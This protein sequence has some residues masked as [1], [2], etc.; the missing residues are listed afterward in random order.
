[1]FQAKPI[2]P[3]Y[4]VSTFLYHAYKYTIVIARKPYMSCFLQM[5]DV[6]TQAQTTRSALGSQRAMFGDVQG[7]VKQLGDKFPVVRGLIGMTLSFMFLR[8][9]LTISFESVNFVEYVCR[10][11]QKEETKGY[12]HPIC[13]HRGLYVV[14]YYILAIKVKKMLC[15][16]RKNEKQYCSRKKFCPICYRIRNL[17]TFSLFLFC[18]LCCKHLL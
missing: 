17:D 1:M 5:D 2:R 10:C 15:Y 16:N 4:S 3:A 12:P 8:L 7:K 11:Y 18:T 6:I 9:V 14:S 13:C